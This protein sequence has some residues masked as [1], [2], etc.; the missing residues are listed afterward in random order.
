MRV[1]F[2]VAAGVMSLA[3][4]VAA[5]EEMHMVHAKGSLVLLV[6]QQERLELPCFL[7]HFPL[8]SSRAPLHQVAPWGDA[9]GS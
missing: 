7:Q 2:A 9:I 5:Q 3:L 8:G 4:S 6:C 1:R